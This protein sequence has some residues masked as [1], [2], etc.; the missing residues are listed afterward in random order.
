MRT[1]KP[2]PQIPTRE[3]AEESA[4]HMRANAILRAKLKARKELLLKSIDDQFAPDLDDLDRLDADHFTAIQLWADANPE[5][6]GR[7]KS[8]DLTHALVGWRT[9]NPALKPL[10]KNTWETVL[11]TLEHRGFLS[12]VRIKTEVNKEA[13]LDR[14][15]TGDNK[16]DLSEIGVKVVQ[17]ETFYVEP[18]LENP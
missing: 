1:K 10:P 14:A 13:I 12:C 16:F 2:L 15:K 18:R 3:Q 7:G 4:G 8:L 5:A 9:G 11:E 6:F 17:T